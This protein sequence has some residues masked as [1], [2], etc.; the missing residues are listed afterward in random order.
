MG[1]LGPHPPSPRGEYESTKSRENAR[2][3]HFLR[4][5]SWIVLS[6]GRPMLTILTYAEFSKVEV[7]SPRKL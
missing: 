1:A 7:R 5:S 3:Q 6:E 4:A 2:T